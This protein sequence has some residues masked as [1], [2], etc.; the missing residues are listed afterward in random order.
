M[1]KWETSKVCPPVEDKC[2]TVVD[3]HLFDLTILARDKGS[4]P[5]KD[6]DGNE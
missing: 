5:L 4:W 3:G 1:F 2:Y 6:P